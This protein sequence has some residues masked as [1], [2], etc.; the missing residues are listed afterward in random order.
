MARWPIVTVLLWPAAVLPGYLVVE[1]YA[2]APG[3]PA[4]APARWPASIPVGRTPGKA[5][6]VMVAH[7]RCPCTRASLRELNRLMAVVD[8][9]AEA[10]VVFADPADT[11]WERTDLWTLA[12]DIPGARVVRDRGDRI[13]R[14][15][16]AWTSGQVLVYDAAGDLL[17]SG[18]IT[19][20]R[21]HEG[22]STGRLAIVDR[23]RGQAPPDHPADVFG[24]ELR[25]PEGSP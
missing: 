11:P 15:L 19:P 8:G 2:S 14:E 7:P 20:A 25:D 23:L 13:T 24:C 3:R 10:V 9:A 21:G 18:G 17:F 6:V 1:R 4:D 5:T 16:G 12:E 22:D